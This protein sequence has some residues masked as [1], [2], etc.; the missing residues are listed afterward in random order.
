MTDK[1]N[2]PPCR[3]FLQ[4]FYLSVTLYACAQRDYVI[5]HFCDVVFVFSSY[6]YEGLCYTIELD[7]F[8]SVMQQRSYTNIFI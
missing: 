6:D 7:L 5:Q 2:P 1:S 3:N 8:L 4:P